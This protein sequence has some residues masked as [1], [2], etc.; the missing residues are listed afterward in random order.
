MW[1]WEKNVS[2]V[3]PHWT[4]LKTRQRPDMAGHVAFPYSLVYNST[5]HERTANREVG[6]ASDEHA[7]EAAVLLLKR[8]HDLN[9]VKDGLTLNC[10]AVVNLDGRPQLFD[11]P[12]VVL[13]SADERVELE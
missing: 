10:K 7:K 12:C 3:E 11:R 1:A 13:D 6:T 9:Q 2:A 8:A 4:A 5:P